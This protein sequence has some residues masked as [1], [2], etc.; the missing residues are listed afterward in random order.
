MN[1]TR[2]P[3]L[4][5]QGEVSQDTSDTVQPALCWQC[6]GRGFTAGKGDFQAGTCGVKATRQVNVVCLWYG[7][8]PWHRRTCRHLTTSGFKRGSA[9]RQEQ[10]HS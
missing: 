3:D 1:L 10:M 5:L 9:D 7:D 6:T 8:V 2:I 4:N